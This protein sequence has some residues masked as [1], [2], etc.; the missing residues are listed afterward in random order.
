M[1]NRQRGSAGVKA[2]VMSLVVIALAAVML[3]SCGRQNGPG[4]VTDTETETDAV[5]EPP[6]DYTDL[7]GTAAEVDALIS[8]IPGAETANAALIDRAYMAYVLLDDGEKQ[9]VTKYEKLQEIRYELTKKYV[10]REYRDTRIPHNRFLLGACIFWTVDD[11]HMQQLVDCD[12]DFV[13]WGNQPES[14][15]WEKYGIGVIGPSNYAGAPG[16]RGSFDS[17]SEIKINPLNPP[18]SEE[19]IRAHLDANHKDY[20]MLWGIDMGDEP[21]VGEFK[22]MNSI[23]S[24][25][26][27][28]IPDA[29]VLINLFPNYASRS[30]LGATDY[31]SYINQF[32]QKVKSSDYICYDHYYFG[33]PLSKTLQNMQIVADA[34]KKYGYEPWVIL[35]SNRSKDTYPPVEENMLR[36]QA[37]LAMTYGYK[38]VIWACWSPGWWLDNVLDSAGNPTNTYYELQKVNAELKALEPV[39]MRYTG[40]SNAVLFGEKSEYASDSYIKGEKIS[41]LKQN[42]ITDIKCGSDEILA[43]GAFKKNVGQG[44]A[45][46]FSDSTDR[47][48]ENPD[49]GPSTVTFRTVK[50]NAVVVS[51]VDGLPTILSPE[52]GV[53][54][55]KINGSHA[56]FVT[57]D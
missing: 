44:E 16:W 31:I 25:T 35:Q 8:S 11:E 1:T 50:E 14:E 37:Y 38:S 18:P 54:T 7:P 34:A 2:A 36:Y 43:V 40:V 46:M 41:T 53:Y 22:G 39:Y 15:L 33:V 29:A 55:L 56:A 28:Y 52:N 5:T 12:I 26:K 30:Q 3:F 6:P 51:W 13:Y 4:Q 47:Y 42:A 27:E 17:K 10:V 20:P 21:A 49:R 23:A 45:I 19:E 48:F 9:A 57:V 24:I 32:C